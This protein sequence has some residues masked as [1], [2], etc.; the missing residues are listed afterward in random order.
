MLWGE[1]PPE[2][3]AS[4]LYSHVSHLRATLGA[5]GANQQ[6]LVTRSRGYQLAIQSDA[7]DSLRFERLAIAARHLLS[8]DPAAAAP[9]F[10]EALSLWR[11]RA[12][13]GFQEEPFARAESLRL[14]EARVA[15]FED[16]IEAEMALGRH[17]AITGELRS[18][19]ADHPTRERPTAQLMR[20]LYHTGRQAEA[21]D[22]FEMLR[23]RLVGE[24]GI[25]PSRELRQLERAVLRQELDDP[26]SRVAEEPSSRFREPRRAVPPL[27]SPRIPLPSLLSRP[28][29]IFV[30]RDADVAHLEQLWKEAAAGELR[31]ALIAGEPGVGKTRLATELATRLHGEGA[32]VLAGRCDEDLGVP[33]QPFVEALRHLVDH[34][35]R[36]ELCQR[37]GRY[38]GELA[39]LLP[40]LSKRVPDLPPVLRSDPETERYRLFDAVAS[41]LHATSQEQPLLLVLDDLQWAAKPTLLL[42]RHVLRW[43]E[44]MRLLVLATYR[45]TEVGRTH[46]LSELLADLSGLDSIERISISGLHEAAVAAFLQQA[47]GHEIDEERSELARVIHR[48]TEGNAFFV[49]EVVRHLIETGGLLQQEGRRVTG[50]TTELGIPEGVRD[51]IGR[52]LCRLSGTGNQVLSLAAVAGE[53]FELGV[54]RQAGSLDEDAVLSALDEAV[55]ARLAVEVP[56]QA[57]RYRFAHALVRATLYEGLTGARRALLHGRA[58]EA[59]ETLHAQQLDDYLPALAHHFARASAPHTDTGK[60]VEYAVLAGNRALAQLANDEA[61]AYFLQALEQL[62]VSEGGRDDVRRLELLITLGEAQRRAGV[63]AHRETLLEAGRLAHER[64]D[65]EGMARA[66][67]ANQRMALMSAVGV[68]DEERVAALDTVLESAIPLA[69]TTRACLLANLGIEL[70]F[71][72]DPERRMA[73]SDEALG[74]A[75]SARDVA[76]L[77]RVLTARFLTLYGPDTLTERLSN[78]TELLAVAPTSRDPA[79]TFW[80]HWLEGG[81]LIEM[82]DMESAHHHHAQAERIAADLG[83]PTL[84]YLA[85]IIPVGSALMEGRID[86]ADRLSVEAFTLGQNSGQPDAPTILLAQ[87]FQ[88]RLEQGRLAE[89]EPLYLAAR[90]QLPRLSSTLG[91]YLVQVYAETGRANNARAVFDELA[92]NSFALPRYATWLS[93]TMAIAEGARSLGDTQGAAILY[94]LLRPYPEVFA[95]GG[96]V[97]AGCTAYYLGVLASTMDRFDDAERHLSYV[98]DVYQRIGAPAHLGR[99]HI[100][101]ARMLIRRQRLGD[102]E[103]AQELLGQVLTT[104]QELGLPNVERRATALLNESA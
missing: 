94:D 16:L 17:A 91:A 93:A 36:E 38:A 45:D 22:C 54:V 60:A 98:A 47:A 80:A 44:P 82:G 2:G 37:L 4:T 68:V 48:E 24:L 32:T 26:P 21:L 8:S 75:R 95:T 103:R 3:A 42:L 71:M 28:G 11:G 39:R 1:Q 62:H 102:A 96:G 34:T 55:N 56:G 76:T 5:G 13:E 74:L 27:P 86:H 50:R 49:R 99:T 53:E 65:V 6:V 41:W 31:I 100:E 59:I 104:A 61:V 29:R 88:I 73:L 25:E 19:V 77:A 64:G 84:Q 85:K 51:V 58:G 72:P 70:V 15:A 30:G 92:A 57:D 90:S 35:N 69:P 79:I 10:R 14:E 83:Q 18:L 81:A 66:A 23:A 20:V 43:T 33:F 97:S 78:M 12:L 52:R 89:V 46:P 7:L 9:S 63:A 101:L 40:E 87:H 67:L